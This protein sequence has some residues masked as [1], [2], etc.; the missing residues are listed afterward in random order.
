MFNKV[1]IANRGEIAIRIM[2][3]CR[4]LEVKTVAVYSDADKNALFAKYADEAYNIGP[5]PVSLSYLNSDAILDVAEKSGA[6]GIHPGYGF[7]SEN[8]NFVDACNKLGITFIGPS[9]KV[10]KQMGSKIRARAAMVKTGVPVV[11]GDDKAISDLDV[12][13]DTAERI[14]Y[15]VMIKASAGGGGIGMKVV[16]SKKEFTESLASIQSVAKSAFGDSTVFIEKYIEEPR[17]IEFQILADKYGDTIHLIERE[18]SIQRRHQKLIEEAP[19]P[20]ITQDLR[21]K[22]GAMAVRAAKAIG[23]ENAGTVEFL[24]SNGE[25]YFLEVNTRL[26]VEHS[27]TEMITGID[28]AKD[29]L[30]IACGDR[31]EYEQEDIKINGWAIEC[32]INAEDPLNNFT[33]SPGKIRKYR[34]AGGPGVRVDSGVHTG[35]TISPFYDS[36]ISKLSVWGRDRQEAIQ[37]MRRALYEYVV[38][39]VTTNLPFHKAVLRNSDFQKGN[40]TTHFIE[41]HNLLDEVEKIIKYE[42]ENGITLASALD[43]G[44]HKIA[45]ISAAINAHLQASRDNK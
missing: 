33:P 29:Q 6:E 43:D 45:A 9:S 25:F 8:Y 10:I 13:Q 41:E 15:P 28:I 44:E 14:G 2:R 18:C 30:H 11:P 17:H 31:L 7:L 4:E 36:M 42:K 16:H 3:A 38:V 22:M 27:I 21:D 1:L 19:S 24:Y 34:S 40:I 23:Y 26:Q 37:R 5:S 32:R 39:G 20:I 35:Y 12:A